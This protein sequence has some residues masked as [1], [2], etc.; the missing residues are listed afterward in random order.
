[1]LFEI[2]FGVV[3]IQHALR[4]GERATMKAWGLNNIIQ[5]EMIQVLEN[6]EEAIITK[7]NDEIKFKNGLGDKIIE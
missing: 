1:M 4:L 5:E 6:L 2:I 3:L 7:K